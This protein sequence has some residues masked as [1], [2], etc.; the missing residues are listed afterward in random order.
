MKINSITLHGAHNYGAMLQAF[1]LK[2][3]LRLQ[4]HEVSVIDFLPNAVTQNNHRVKLSK[5]PKTLVRSGVAALSWFPWRKRFQAFENFKNSKMNL[6]RH[7]E[8]LGDLKAA[9]PESD[10]YICGSDQIWNPERKFNPAYFL[11]FGPPSTRRISYAASLGVD[12]ASEEKLKELGSHLDRFDAV[13]VRETSG[14]GIVAAAGKEAEVV[15]DPTLL[16]DKARWAEIATPYAGT[17]KYILT[18]CLEESAEFN[19]VLKKL[20]AHTG[21]PVV[22]IAG[23]IIN[24]TKPVDRIIKD[25]G[26]LEFLGLFLKAEYIFT[27]SFHGMAFA[28][29]FGRPLVGIRHSTRNARMT[30]LLESVGWKDSQVGNETPI[31]EIKEIAHERATNVDE[32]VLS[33]TKQSSIEFLNRSLG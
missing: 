5:N 19:S 21:L 12:K 11:D 23:S 17:G 15:L 16:L 14:A 29:N 33:T 10:A 6:T 7:Y 2:D 31:G 32:D 8:T 25:A 26:P 3:H 1:A 20:S 22:H 9:P 28:L 24:R 18:Y 30:T 4:G 13:S 27:N